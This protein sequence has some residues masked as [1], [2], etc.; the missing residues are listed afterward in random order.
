MF[1]FYSQFIQFLPKDISDIKLSL[2]YMY[3]RE[4]LFFWGIDRNDPKTTP[5][6]SDMRTSKEKKTEKSNTFLSKFFEDNVGSLII[7]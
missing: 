7:A 6:K 3:L 1:Q 4:T 5:K 2:Y